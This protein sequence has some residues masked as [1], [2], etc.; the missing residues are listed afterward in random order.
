[1]RIDWAK[2]GDYIR[3]HHAVLPDW[4]NEA[5]ED[6]NA[7]WLVPDPASRSGHSVRVI[8]YSST[9]GT[10]L[11][12]ILVDADANPVELPDGDWWGSNAWVANQRDRQLYG[13]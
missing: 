4:A 12:V 11:T 8:G 1:M 6:E 10:I 3:M 9:A 5:V 2:R 13:G 7:L